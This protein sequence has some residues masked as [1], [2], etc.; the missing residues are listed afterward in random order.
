MFGFAIFL[1]NC[2]SFG[3]H[4]E[5]AALD[6]EQVDTQEGAVAFLN[7]RVS[8]IQDKTVSWKRRYL[9]TALKL[10][11]VGHHTYTHDDR[12]SVDFQKPN[13]WRL[14]IRDVNT[15][16]EGIFE[17]EIS[18]HPAQVLRFQLSVHC[19]YGNIGNSHRSFQN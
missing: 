14:R 18:T 9:G 11:T 6:V 16:D 10:L 12:F 7:C 15:E 8:Q 4:F 17:C 3:P 5:D 13:N 1:T 19:K 2:V